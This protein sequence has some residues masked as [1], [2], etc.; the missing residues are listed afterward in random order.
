MVAINPDFVPLSQQFAAKGYEV[1]E[2]TTKV[3]GVDMRSTG[4]RFAL[5]ETGVESVTR[6]HINGVLT[7]EMQPQQEIAPG[8]V[9]KNDF[10][11]S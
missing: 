5:D 10:N 9:V 7:P 6:T 11:L 4:M 2:L 8:A 1:D 3:P